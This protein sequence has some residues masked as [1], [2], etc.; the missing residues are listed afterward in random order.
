MHICTDVSVRVCVLSDNCFTN[1][2]FSICF[3]H[4]EYMI[5][6]SNPAGET[7]VGAESYIKG[8]FF[9]LRAA[10]NRCVQKYERSLAKQTA[11]VSGLTL[12]NFPKL[13][14]R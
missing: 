4:A 12:F 5:V 14:R 3:Y 10:F 2:L 1:K 13:S 7:A 8:L 11:V 6:G 9:A